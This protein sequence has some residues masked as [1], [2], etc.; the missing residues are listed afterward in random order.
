M[1]ADFA[2]PKAYKRSFRDLVDD[3]EERLLPTVGR[4]VHYQIVDENGNK[5]IKKT[6]KPKVPPAVVGGTASVG[7]IAGGVACLAGPHAWIASGVALLGAGGVSGGLSFSSAKN[8]D[9]N[10]FSENHDT[11]TSVFSVAKVVTG[12]LAL[13][14]IEILEA[15]G[16]PQLFNLETDVF[17]FS[18]GARPEHIP[19]DVVVSVGKC[20]THTGGFEPNPWKKPAAWDHPQRW[21]ETNYGVFKYGMGLGPRDRADH[22]GKNFAEIRFQKFISFFRKDWHHVYHHNPSYRLLSVLRKSFRKDEK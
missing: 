7:C 18:S 8:T 4:P 15:M 11:P 20:L 21:K 3:L 2:E 17:Q 19:A 22:L 1:N 6:L 14:T 12:F 13:M 10:H 16:S 5:L 9:R